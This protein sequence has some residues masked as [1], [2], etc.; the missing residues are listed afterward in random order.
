MKSSYNVE[1]NLTKYLDTVKNTQTIHYVGRVSYV[2][3]LDIQ[4]NGPRCV[5]GE[6]C[7][8]RVPSLKTSVLAE[9]VGLDETSVKLSAFGNTRGIEVGCEVV[10][11]GKTLQVPVGKSLL[12]RVIDA[13][14]A[15]CDNKGAIVP[16]TYYP[17]E[18]D[19]PDPMTR[20]PIDRRIT[21][22]VRAIDTLLTVGKGQRLGIFAGSGVGKSTL[23]SMIAR[24]TDAD[25]N[26]IALIGERGRE[27]LDF[28]N[29][30]LGEEGLK[31]SVI[32]VATSDQPSICRLRASY[33]ATAVAEYFRDQGNDV[34]F[35]FD[36][37]T[38]FAHA[39]REIGLAK[40]EPPAQKGYPPSVFDM[41]PKLLERAGTN[42]KGTITAFYNVLVDSDDMNE[43]ITDKV[44]GTLDG[45]IVL[46]RKLAQSYHYPAI[47]VLQS[48]SRLSRR[49]TGTKTKEAC[50]VI[51]ELMSVYE[52][53]ELM[54]T[55]GAYEKG[56]SPLIDKAIAMHDDIEKFLK[57]EEF[58]KCTMNDSLKKLSELSGIEIP[59]EEFDENAGSQNKS[60][61][62]IVKE[63][64]SET[65]QSD[66]TS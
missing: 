15:P 30:D 19:P 26:V 10:A 58:D 59:E 39:Q 35:M 43:P 55:T 37:V 9:V 49:V 4:S 7:T 22:V 46:N 63:L 42:D 47:D 61:V 18:C 31:R 40:G 24:N 27:V 1:L 48:I 38:R 8:I 5:I 44:R 54:I 51:R 12:G 28:I 14:G 45:H 66:E 64:S 2:N 56:N 23:L 52:S 33:V 16:E 21:T 36:N 6:I 13:T 17:A 60:T 34:M 32:I 11:S 29:R 53:N 57:Q 41:I 25:I 62:Q 3:G 65:I 20:K 50:G